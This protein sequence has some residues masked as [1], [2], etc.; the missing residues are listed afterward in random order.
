MRNQIRISPTLD[1]KFSFRIARTQQE[2]CE[3]YRILH[4]SYLEMGYAKSH[5]SGM[6]I[7][8]YFALPSTTT[9]IAL[10][11]N[12]V[13]GTIS[14]IR[15]GSFGVPMD[16]A[17][18]LSEF[19]ER[20]EVIA[21]VS[22]LAIDSHFRQKR[23]ALFLPLL[24]Y[25][26]EYVE[27]FM[28]L[29]SI[30]I[31]VNPS[32][33]DFYEAFLSFKRLK[34]AVVKDYSFANGNPGIGLYLN[35]KD[36]PKK[37]AKLYNHKDFVKNLY[38]YFVDFKLPHFVLPERTFN[39]SSDPV[40]SPQMLQYFF[41]TRSTV[42]NDL[43]IQ[44]KMGLAAVYPKAHYR[45]VIP[46]IHRTHVRHSVNLKAKLSDNEDILLTVLDLSL[47]GLCIV[48]HNKLQGNMELKID[49]AEGRLALVKGEI[50]W[51]D[52][53][54]HIFGIHLSE[55]DANWKDFVDYMGQDFQG[56]TANMVKKIA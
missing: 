36:A 21:E 26:W 39:K 5:I 17:F 51:K 6:R 22:S 11:E 27:R 10:Y 1:P 35:I 31:T 38:H 45:N 15:R 33:S 46:N 20:N 13:V 47:T 54:R 34:H 32:M 53:D 24:K 12:K 28:N 44:E 49:V 25:F 29:D 43:T 3:A 30:I 50:R 23:G 16:S 2:L 40:M 19:V 4:D 14:I 7:I 48:S 8:K 37:F 9:L 55:T 52:L 41:V 42:F 18:N 56:L